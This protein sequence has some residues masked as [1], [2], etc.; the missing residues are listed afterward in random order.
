MAP[1]SSTRFENEGD[2]V[3]QQQFYWTLAHQTGPEMCRNFFRHFRTRL[4]QPWNGVLFSWAEFWLRSWTLRGFQI[5]STLQESHIGLISSSRLL[6]VLAD[7]E[8]GNQ[9]EDCYR[10]SSRKRAQVIELEDVV[11]QGIS[12]WQR[13]NCVLL[14]QPL[15]IWL[16][17]VRGSNRGV[18]GIYVRAGKV[19]HVPLY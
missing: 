6:Q 10:Q 19:E 8:W 11:S 7:I 5:S 14:I 4:L 2:G 3:E 17:H 12:K 18:F 15:N 1:L 13:E 9:S 16:R